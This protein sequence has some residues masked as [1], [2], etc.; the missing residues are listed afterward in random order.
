LSGGLFSYD[1]V[2]PSE[3]GYAVVA[4]EWVRMINQNGGS[5]EEINLRPFMGLSA[6]SQPRSGLVE[7]TREAY[8]GLLEVFSGAVQR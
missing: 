8:E 2:H 6:Q 5:L 1:G 3:L 7:L 4:N